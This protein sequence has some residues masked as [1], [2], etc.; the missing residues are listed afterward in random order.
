M[1][2]KGGT[3]GEAIRP[4]TGEETDRSLVVSVL[5]VA[6]I[7]T[8]G[9]TYYLLAVLATPIVEDTGWP[10][11]WVMG[12]LSAGMLVAGI[13]SPRVGDCIQ[14]AGGR[15]MLASSAVL[16]S[17]GL[18]CMAAS[19]NMSTYVAAWLLLG[20][21]MGAGLYD[22]AFATLGRLFGGE[23][24][25]AIAGLTLIGGFASTL[26]WPLSAMLVS[27]FGWRGACLVY[28]G[29]HLAVVLPLYLLT[30]PV[31]ARQKI[32]K[33]SVAEENGSTAPAQ[34]RW[35]LC[36]ILIAGIL[37]VGAMV[38]TL[39][40]VY[41]I[42]I[43]QFR[44]VGMVTAIAMA[45]LIGPSQVGA[46]A[47]EFLLGRYYH[48]VWTMLA[49]S[50]FIMVG[51]GLLWTGLPLATAAL[52]LYG[53]GVGIEWIAR[54][55]LP[56]VVFGEQHYPALMGRIAMPSLIGQAV[57]P[58]LGALL[59]GSIGG[60]AMLLALFAAASFKLALAGFLT[61]LVTTQ[62]SNQFQAVRGPA[63]PKPTDGS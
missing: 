63:G 14:R 13:V 5:G 53:A 48:P 52:V 61:F 55:T 22:A 19:F 1:G 25:S 42:S 39:L 32:I 34:G 6:Q 4:E 7:L 11:S 37:T 33:P 59:I 43:L 50:S 62:P 17:L 10:L 57:A 18:A 38:S 9:S 60:N 45:A 35:T 24:R 54:G 15:C 8:W 41:V 46:R 51:I 40:S 31:E 29:M 16:L 44:G 20:T 30:L 2:K 58:F 26:C 49:S 36:F 23:A 12:G 56:L 47:V 21:G 27:Q 28:A 3:G